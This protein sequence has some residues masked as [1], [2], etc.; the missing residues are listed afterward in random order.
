[1]RRPPPQSPVM[2]VNGREIPVDIRVN[3]RARRLILKVDPFRPAILL[4]CPS[5][6]QKKTALA[7]A[8]ERQEWIREQFS[9]APPAQPFIAGATIPLRGVRHEIISAPA[10]RR[11]VDAHT[12]PSQIIVGGDPTH[13]GRRLHDWL[14]REARKE[15]SDQADEFCKA[16]G[17]TRRRI[18][19]RD[20]KT[21][22]GSCSSTGTISFSWR[23]ILAPRF[24]YRYVI[25]HEVSHL[26]HMDHSASFWQTVDTLISDR[27]EAED[28]L[29]LNGASLYGYGTN[30]RD[31]ASQAAA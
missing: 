16:L 29:K 15:F 9:D 18:S 31:E 6:R 19:V 3:R 28:W 4:T 10:L 27:I 26:R 12:S 8:Q 23:L 17:V 21:R 11:S 14:R 5:A 24:V 25:A 22:W 30:L 1:M 20:T 7:F 2:I 13:L